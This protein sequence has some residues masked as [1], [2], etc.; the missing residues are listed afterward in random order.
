[1]GTRRDLGVLGWCPQLFYGCVIGPRVALRFRPASWFPRPV[2]F[3]GRCA[4]R[5]GRATPERVSAGDG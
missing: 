4:L 1:M 2:E 3:A 5:A